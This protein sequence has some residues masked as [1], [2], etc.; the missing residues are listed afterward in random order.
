MWGR[1][2][3][4][5]TASA[6]GVYNILYYRTSRDEKIIRQEGSIE[7]FRRFH[8]PFNEGWRTALRTATVYD[9]CRLTQGR[10]LGNGSYVQHTSPLLREYHFIFPL[11]LPLLVHVKVNFNKIPG[12]QTLGI[13]IGALT[14]GG[15]MFVI[16][17]HKHLLPVSPASVPWLWLTTTT[18]HRASTSTRWHFAFGAIIR[19]CSVV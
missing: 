19:I 2:L 17:T 1:N 13:P 9:N 16:P 14:F 11:S 12:Q 4:F 6:I 3:P 8:L 18:S 10:V 15:P 7:R 5:P